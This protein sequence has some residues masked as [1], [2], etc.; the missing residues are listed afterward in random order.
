[1]PPC[2]ETTLAHLIELG[3]DDQTVSE[4]QFPPTTL[5][6]CLIL[7][8]TMKGRRHSL[9]AA[10][11]SN[12]FVK[13]RRLYMFLILDLTMKGRRHSPGA[14]IYYIPGHL[15]DAVTSGRQTNCEQDRHLVPLNVHLARA[16]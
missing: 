10:V 12:H 16:F 1:M 4:L 15:F 5:Y 7:D 6:M 11:Y 8:L 14:A 13:R 2:H 9:G 3:A